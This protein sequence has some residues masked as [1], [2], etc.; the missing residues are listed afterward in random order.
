M[1]GRHPFLC[2]SEKA[3]SSVLGPQSFFVVRLV[4]CAVLLPAC[5]GC[6]YRL[7]GTNVSAP[8]EIRSMAVGAFENR[9]REFGLDRQLMFAIEREF[10]RRGL[11]RVVED[12]D[13]GEA[14]L[15]GTIRS[16]TAYPVAFDSRDEALQYE[17]ELTLDAELK[18]RSDGAILWKASGMTAIED[19]VVARSVVVPSSSQFQRGTL[20]LDDLNALT[21]IQLAETEKRLA[22]NR[23]VGSI[24]VD[25]YDRLLDDF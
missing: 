3:Q 8:G 9:S 7:A 17:A 16:F 2:A 11:L 5:V 23:L 12:P 13:G 20:N 19:Y 24:V 15:T 4:A 22:I 25:L 18:R 14:V 10:Y 1:L 21:N 6:G